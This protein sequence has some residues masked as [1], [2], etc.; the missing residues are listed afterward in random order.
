MSIVH[1]PFFTARTGLNLAGERH[2]LEEENKGDGGVGGAG[3]GQPPPKT[4]TP[5]KT[6]ASGDAAELAALRAKVRDFEARD[7]KAADDQ[8]RA[9][10]ERLKSEGKLQQL[11]D[12]KEKDLGDLKPLADIGRQFLD[13]EAKRIDALKAGLTESQRAILDSEPNIVRRGQLANE[14]QA[15]K[16]AAGAID[17]GKGAGGAGGPPPPPGDKANVEELLAKGM[18]PEEIQRK[19]PEEYQ[20]YADL[21]LPPQ[22]LTS[23]A[24]Q[25]MARTAKSN[26]KG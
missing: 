22:K 9:H 21:F 4:E 3:G 8:K 20:A 16:S 25:Q 12:A 23:F 6:E 10:E 17:K 5:P 7:T 26:G 2:L 19:H 15:L 14:F 24:R 18:S 1:V 11:L 13:A